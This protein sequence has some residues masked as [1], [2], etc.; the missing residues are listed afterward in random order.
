[1]FCIN[2]QINKILNLF[3]TKTTSKI[4]SFVANC[5]ESEQSQ[6]LVQNLLEQFQKQSVATSVDKQAELIEQLIL[7]EAKKDPFFKQFVVQQGQQIADAM[8]ESAIASAIR[9]AHSQLI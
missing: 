3:R 2:K 1:M 7:T 8:V 6:K 5:S 4:C 9:A